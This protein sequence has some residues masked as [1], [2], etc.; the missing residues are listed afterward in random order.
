MAVWIDEK[1]KKKTYGPFDGA[2][3]LLNVGGLA[4]P[5]G[6]ATIA[7]GIETRRST[8]LHTAPRAATTTNGRLPTAACASDCR[9]M[10]RRSWRLKRY[11]V[12]RRW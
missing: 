2:L 12:R 9:A 5:R 10:S 8:T 7:D 3:L 6:Q 4:R 1:K 11:S